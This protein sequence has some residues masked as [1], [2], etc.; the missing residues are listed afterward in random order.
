MSPSACTHTFYVRV[1]EHSAAAVIYSAQLQCTFI[2]RKILRR[3]TPPTLIHV[4][5]T[6]NAQR[7]LRSQ[8]RMIK[9]VY[10][11]GACECRR[12][13]IATYT[14]TLTHTH[15]Q[16]RSHAHALRFTALHARVNV[17]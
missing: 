8:Y 3:H 4:V 11:H 5:R 2:Q 15:T 6:L 12:V 7:S 17:I 14:H 9:P 1:F 10:M 13:L 16:P